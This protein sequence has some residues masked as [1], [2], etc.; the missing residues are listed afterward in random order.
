[1]NSLQR[2]FFKE[3]RFVDDDDRILGF[4][5]RQLNVKFILRN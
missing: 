5:I 4:I 3:N 1:M 2:W